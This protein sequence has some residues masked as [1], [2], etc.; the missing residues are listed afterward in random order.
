M[1]A[2]PGN[3]FDT[4]NAL[5]LPLPIGLKNIER[6]VSQRLINTFNGFDV[7]PSGVEL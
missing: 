6:N 5:P 3:N 1:A 4:A 2:R 7:C